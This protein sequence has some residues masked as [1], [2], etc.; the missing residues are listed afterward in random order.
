LTRLLA[1]QRGGCLEEET[2]F[3]SGLRAEIERRHRERSRPRLNGVAV[4]T[5]SA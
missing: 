1:E 4:A 2:A 5:R 3:G